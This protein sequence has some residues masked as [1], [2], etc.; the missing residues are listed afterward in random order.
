MT[1]LLMTVSNAPKPTINHHIDHIHINRIDADT[2]STVLFVGTCA[3]SI[4]C[5]ESQVSGSTQASGSTHE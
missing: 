5:D 1:V 4:I 3:I 2:E